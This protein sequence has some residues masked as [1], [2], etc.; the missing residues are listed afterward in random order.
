MTYKIIIPSYKR[1]DIF[2]THTLPMLMRTDVKREIY[3]FV[4]DQEEDKA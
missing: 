2:K 4:A 1:H 3:V